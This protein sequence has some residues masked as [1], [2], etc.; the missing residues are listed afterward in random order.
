MAI[1][2]RYCCWSLPGL[3]LS[4]MDPPAAAAVR[5]GTW[6]KASDKLATRATALAVTTC[7]QGRR[8]AAWNT[9]MISLI[10]YPT[11]TACPG[12]IEL[13]HLTRHFS[14]AMRLD[15]TQWCNPSI[16]SGLDF[17]FGVRGAPGALLP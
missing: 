8:A 16:L 14:I 7:S 6:K 15:V 9:Y 4:H 3:P 11:H 2:G 1:P 5:T 17:L 10:P 12:P 13:R